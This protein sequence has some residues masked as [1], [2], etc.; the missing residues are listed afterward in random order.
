MFLNNI[1][2]VSIVFSLMFLEN[3]A[4]TFFFWGGP[5]SRKPVQCKKV[6]LRSHAED[7]G[8]KFRSKQATSFGGIR[9][10]KE[11]DAVM[12]RCRSLAKLLFK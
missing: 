6:K 9:D 5:L 1:A 2:I 12:R 7:H 4:T 8:K 11:Q 3:C 10:L